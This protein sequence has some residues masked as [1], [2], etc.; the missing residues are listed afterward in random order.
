MRTKTQDVGGRSSAGRVLSILLLA[1]LV[2]AFAACSD[3]STA[4]P[5]DGAVIDDKST[6]PNPDQGMTPK[7][8]KG[9]P[10]K[11]DKGTAPPPDKGTPPPPDKG[12][13]P[14]PDK[15]TPPPIPKCI[16]G[17]AQKD[18]CGGNLVG[19]WKYKAGCISPSS[20]DDFK[21]ACPGAKISNTG[22]AMDSGLHSLVM[23]SD[24]SFTR[25]VKGKAT[26]KVLVPA[27]CAILGCAA[28]VTAAKLVL[29]TANITCKASAGGCDCDVILPVVT[30]DQGTY[31]VNGGKVTATV[32]GKNYDYY[33][34]VKG[35]ALLYR[36][37]ETNPI[38]R[39]VSYVLTK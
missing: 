16:P 7:P 8:D 21:K 13:P 32:N 38:D 6:T 34:C 37:T 28:V 10:P 23:K 29:P 5:A 39:V 15:G 1:G 35:G 4:P 26:A 17:L 11:P 9:T 19:S 33:F 18:A 2:L 3:D 20:F 27:S 36:G 31:K 12:T 22:Y 25:A 24:K 30:L 14:P